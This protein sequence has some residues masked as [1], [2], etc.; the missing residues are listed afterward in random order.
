MHA[1]RHRL[2]QPTASIVGIVPRF[3]P[4]ESDNKFFEITFHCFNPLVPA[5]Y[6]QFSHLQ[7]SEY[8][9]SQVLG[10]RANAFQG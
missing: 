4:I 5:C 3:E 1:L 2:K 9:V 6:Q 10:M 8:A 7:A